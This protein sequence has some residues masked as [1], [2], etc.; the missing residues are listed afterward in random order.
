MNKLSYDLSAASEIVIN[1]D[2]MKTVNLIKFDKMHYDLSA[3][4]KVTQGSLVKSLTLQF[5]DA[6]KKYAVSNNGLLDDLS[7]T[8]YSWISD[9]SPKILR[10]EWKTELTEYCM[11]NTDIIEAL[12]YE[13]DNNNE[14]II[15]MEDASSEN[16]LDYNDFGFSLTDKYD[17]ITNFM[18]IDQDEKTGMDMLNDYLQIYQR[19]V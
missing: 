16:I 9:V 14:F 17:H 7:S 8:I 5:L 15:V 10:N 6:T 3:S 11:N 2:F 12:I 4:C 19:G 13:D 18:V 1:N